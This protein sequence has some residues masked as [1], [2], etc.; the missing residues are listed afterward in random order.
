M[1]F[2]APA[3]ALEGKIPGISLEKSPMS[4]I[5]SRQTGLDIANLIS[6]WFLLLGGSSQLVS[7][8]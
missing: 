8:L 4:P 6:S 5:I 1:D 3:E 7:G 2:M